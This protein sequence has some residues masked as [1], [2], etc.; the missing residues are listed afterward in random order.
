MYVFFVGCVRQIE[1]DGPHLVQ[2]HRLCPGSCK[3]DQ[4]LE[5]WWQ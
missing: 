5:D 2:Q 3:G 4:R 1:R